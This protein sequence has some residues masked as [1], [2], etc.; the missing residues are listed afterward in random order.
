MSVKSNGQTFEGPVAVF[1]NVTFG[2]GET[3]VVE[4]ITFSVERGDFLVLIGPNG[5]GKTTLIKLAIG[6]EKLQKGRIV[7]FGQE[8]SSFKDWQR[9]GY[10]PQTASAFRVRFP[11]TVADVVA[12]GEYRG[13]SAGA[14]F[15]RKISP[16]AEQ[17]LNTVGMWE[18]RNRLI[19]ELSVGQ[20]QR[21]LIGRAIVHSPELLIMDEPTAGVDKLGQ[22][23]FFSL[24]R[25]LRE[26]RPVTLILVSHDIGVVLHEAT[27]VACINGRLQ[28]YNNVG[29]LT[30]SD[31][32]ELYGHKVDMLV[33]RHD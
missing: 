19:N 24:I 25:S 31:L 27:K 13:M 15:R 10:V 29:D 1:E 20:Q 23:Q 17:A 8:L 18:Y 12:M 3:P 5:S 9:I 33:H 11:A 14:I 22:E 6:I 7:L 32:T 2:Y 26:T 30:D 21:V 28:S 4:D 16:E